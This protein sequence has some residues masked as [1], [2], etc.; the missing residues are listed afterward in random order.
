MNLT[1][2]KEI[3]KWF[4]LVSGGV[5]LFISIYMQRKFIFE[6]GNTAGLLLLIAMIAAGATLL[7]GI[8]SLPRWQGFVAL[9]ISAYAMYWL[10]FGKLYALA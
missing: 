4:G 3:A 8:L 2:L 10:V 1:S 6:S 9:A 7:A 5:F